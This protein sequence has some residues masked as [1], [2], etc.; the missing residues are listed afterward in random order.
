M[1]GLSVYTLARGCDLVVGVGDRDWRDAMEAAFV[2]QNRECVIGRDEQHR[3]FPEFGRARGRGPFL[4]LESASGIGRKSCSSTQTSKGRP[5]MLGAPFTTLLNPCVT[6]RL[7][8]NR[9]LSC[10]T[11]PAC[12]GPAHHILNRVRLLWAVNNTCR[13]P[14]GIHRRRP[15]KSP[16]QLGRRL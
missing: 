6:N 16:W 11:K 13:S 4:V 14:S 8:R 1:E 3:A 9:C 5:S 15:P 10:K 12:Q 2:L 7:D